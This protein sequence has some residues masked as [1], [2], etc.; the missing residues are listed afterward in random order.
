MIKKYI[1]L[2]AVLFTAPLFTEL[3]SAQTDSM[4]SFRLVLNFNIYSKAQTTFDSDVYTINNRPRPSFRLGGECKINKGEKNKL[5]TGLYLDRMPINRFIFEPN[6]KEV[7]AFPIIYQESILWVFTLPVFIES[8]F[9]HL[10]FKYGLEFSLINK[11]NAF[12]SGPFQTLIVNG[13]EYDDIYFESLNPH[14]G[15]IGYSFVLGIGRRFKINKRQI[16][17]DLILRK[18]FSNFFNIDFRF[19]DLNNLDK[20]L[21]GR[22]DY[23]G[24]FVGLNFSTNIW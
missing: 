4:S 2:G 16:N 5:F 3:L 8:N 14:K 1:I 19:R 9:E 6:H 11:R 20:H 13:V 15:E 23:S 17:I 21:P 18:V 10:Y 22:F 7:D 24:S 12:A